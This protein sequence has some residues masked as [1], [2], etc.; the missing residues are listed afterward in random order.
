[1]IK[2]LFV[3]NGSK[4]HE[5][6]ILHEKQFCFSDSFARGQVCIRRQNCTKTILY[7]R[8]KFHEDTYPY[9]LCETKMI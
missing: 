1:M 6:S 7:E 3:G 8:T 2:R 5:G 9:L 4:F